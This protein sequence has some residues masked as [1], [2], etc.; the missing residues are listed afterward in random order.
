MGVSRDGWWVRIFEEHGDAVEFE[1]GVHGLWL[2]P[3]LDLDFPTLKQVLVAALKESGLEP[4]IVNRFPYI[5]V[6]VRGLRW[7]SNSHLRDSLKWAPY[8]AWEPRVKKALKKICR[9]NFRPKGARRL[10]RH[11]LADPTYKWTR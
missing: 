5:E 9:Q 11:L 3:V 1:P 6:L 10:A 7:P 4:G 2:T 8:F